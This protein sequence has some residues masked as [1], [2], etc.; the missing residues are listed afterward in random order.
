MWRWSILNYG[1]GARS[2]EI[3]IING[4]L[5]ALYLINVLQKRYLESV[6]KCKI[7]LSETIHENFEKNAAAN[8]VPNSSFFGI[9][10]PHKIKHYQSWK[11]IMKQQFCKKCRSCTNRR[12]W[13][14]MGFDDEVQLSR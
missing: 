9:F 6:E 2:N 3:E 4:L 12:M 7:N 10:F 11:F 13:I 8:D 14:F 1:L 5:D